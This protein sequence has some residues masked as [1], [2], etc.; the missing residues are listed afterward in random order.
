MTDETLYVGRL[1]RRREDGE[2]VMLAFHNIDAV[3]AFGGTITDPMP[4][5]WRGD[6]FV[7]GAGA[8]EATRTG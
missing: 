5:G 6:A 7:A 4:V 1:I 2:W 8:P 3:G